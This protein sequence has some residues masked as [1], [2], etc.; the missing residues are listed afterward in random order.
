MPM[1]SLVSHSD[2]DVTNSIS[3]P[4]FAEPLGP[5]DERRAKAAMT[6]ALD[7]QGAG[8]TVAWNNPDSGAKGTFIPVGKAYPENE[9]VCRAFLAEID[10]KNG[11]KSMQGTACA[12][13]DGNWSVTDAKPWK[14][15]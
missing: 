7:P 4:L 10:L 9:R 5:E 13:K 6:P 15:T 12:D 14:K 8:S 2:E 1:H 3:R 11:D